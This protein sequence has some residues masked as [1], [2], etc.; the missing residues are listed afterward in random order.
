M[1]SVQKYPQ[2][3][4]NNTDDFESL[5][6]ISEKDKIWDERKL[7][8][9][10]LSAVAYSAGMERQFQRLAGCAGVLS[11]AQSDD[12]NGIKLRGAHF[13]KY[14]HC[15]V[16][17]WRRSLRNKAI[18]LSALPTIEAQY[19]KHRWLFLTLTVRNVEVTRLRETLATMS[20]AWVRMIERKDW[21]AVGWIRSLE[22]TR[23]EDGSAHPHYHAMLMVPASYFSGQGYI[24]QKSW[25]EGWRT[26]L[27]VDYDPVVDVRTIKPKSNADGRTA[28]YHAV[29]EVA[30]YSTKTNDLTVDG[31]WF[32][33]FAE[34]VR[35]SK[36]LTTGG[37][38]KGIMK[39][40]DAETDDDLV[41]VEGSAEDSTEALGNIFVSWVRKRRQYGRRKV[42][43]L[44]K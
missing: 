33:I 25:S 39:R 42:Q 12:G 3:V 7:S 24:T 5:S 10:T 21:P 40:I 15:P 22:I 44:D 32:R 2:A 17:T 28:L 31:D 37:V 13:C 35:G 26:A 29:A 14:R 16:C 43:F 20:R 4:K 1:T 11:F 36:M 18:L 23:G 27:R 8:A 34:Q 30:K 19:P 41:H 38:L 9:D 6:S